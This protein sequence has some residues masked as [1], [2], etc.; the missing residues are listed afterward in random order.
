MSQIRTQ[1]ELYSTEEDTKEKEFSYLSTS[2]PQKTEYSSHTTNN[3]TVPLSE[4]CLPADDLADL[5][6]GNGDGDDDDNGGRQP[7]TMQVV[8]QCIEGLEVTD[9]VQK[10][11][12]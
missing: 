6:W 1:W 12:W 11:K 9:V 4:I 2:L 5:E 3:F 10:R 7:K 8:S